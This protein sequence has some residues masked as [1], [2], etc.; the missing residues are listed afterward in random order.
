MNYFKKIVYTVVFSLFSLLLINPVQA[1]AQK[2]SATIKQLLQERDYQIKELMG[3]EETKL[4]QKKRDELKNIVNNIIEYRAMAK[5]ALGNTYDELSESERDEFVDLF[6]T[7][8]RD[9]IGRA[10]CR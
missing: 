1:W 6:S 7:L 4:S 10:S 9:Q 5:K 3:P 2:N 8:V